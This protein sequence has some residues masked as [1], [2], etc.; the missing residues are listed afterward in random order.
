M[1]GRF[2]SDLA[3]GP[4]SVWI[5]FGM[6]IDTESKFLCDSITTPVLDLKVKVTDFML[7]FCVKVFTMTV[8][9]KPLI[10]MLK[11]YVKDFTMSFYAKP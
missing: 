6:M 5:M 8:F 4:T 7:K 2:A 3:T 9:A 1:P 11:F 10:D